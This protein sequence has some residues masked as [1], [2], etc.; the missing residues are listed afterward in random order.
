MES[1]I[2]AVGVGTS[3]IAAV[4]AESGFTSAV[5]AETRHSIAAV[6]TAQHDPPM[7]SLPTDTQEQAELSVQADMA[8]FLVSNA[9]LFTLCFH[10]FVSNVFTC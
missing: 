1:S 2:A 10:S 7:P 6:P 8:T 4:D 5:G 9:N 3:S